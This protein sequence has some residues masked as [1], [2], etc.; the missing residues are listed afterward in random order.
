MT[1]LTAIPTEV[2]LLIIEKIS[3]EDIR[4]LTSVNKAIYQTLL[5]VRTT[6]LRLTKEFHSCHVT[7][8]SIMPVDLALA[9]CSQKDAQ[10][11]I[12]ELNVC[13]WST[14]PYP[15]FD[16]DSSLPQSYPQYSKDFLQARV[17]RGAGDIGQIQD[18]DE[19]SVLIS[20]LHMFDYLHEL[21]LS[22]GEDEAIQLL[23]Y[24]SGVGR[25]RRNHSMPLQL[26]SVTIFMTDAVSDVS[27]TIDLMHMLTLIPSVSSLKIYDLCISSG[28]LAEA[29]HD[30]AAEYTLAELEF[31]R[32]SMDAKFLFSIVQNFSGISQ[33]T[34]DAVNMCAQD[35]VN[36][37]PP[38]P[39]WICQALQACARNS[40]RSLIIRPRD[41]SQDPH[42][43]TGDLTAFKSLQYLAIDYH[44]ARLT[45]SLGPSL[46]ESIERI[47]LYYEYEDDIGL[48][49]SLVMMADDK[50]EDGCFER[51]NTVYVFVPSEPFDTDLL[52]DYCRRAGIR[53]HVI[54]VT[55]FPQTERDRKSKLCSCREQARGAMMRCKGDRDYCPR[56]YHFECL[57]IKRALPEPWVCDYCRD[58]KPKAIKGMTIENQAV[59]DDPGINPGS[60]K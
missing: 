43:W 52:S 22:L 46:P 16:G 53:L 47:D 2:L 40:L 17:W 3:P 26:K 49:Q 25:L 32:C 20:L 4:N 12:K 11:H 33:F 6:N 34:I 54:A 18:G 28:S 1:T 37:L 7:G 29:Q 38:D 55:N 31:Y 48:C 30:F 9:V 39:F 19:F 8:G 42:A 24:M 58:T 44:S 51:L 5:H 45:H 23:D 27:L 36:A 56:W 57:N 35:Y 59:T 21:R 14:E 10:Y 13:G 60:S 15:E 41:R 50:L